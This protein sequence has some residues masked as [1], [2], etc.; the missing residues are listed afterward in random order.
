MLA[1]HVADHLA[2]WEHKLSA[3]LALDAASDAGLG[4]T[5][6][7]YPADQ[8]ISAERD[9]RVDLGGGAVLDVYVTASP[10]TETSQVTVSFGQVWL[11]VLGPAPPLS[12]ELVSDGTAVWAPNSD[13]D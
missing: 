4:P 10:S 2:V 9:A 1:G 5:L 13:G 3:A 11:R 12:S 6:A 8:R 7:R